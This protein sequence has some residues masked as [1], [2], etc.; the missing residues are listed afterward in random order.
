MHYVSGL[1][2]CINHV[3]IKN[4]YL[5]RSSGTG[6]NKLIFNVYIYARCISLT[7]PAICYMH[8]VN[9]ICTSSS[10]NYVD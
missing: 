1:F 10:V 9:F 6:N 8:L 4:V 2:M 3:T 7:N 5:L